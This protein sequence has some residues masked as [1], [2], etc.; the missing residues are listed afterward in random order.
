M[1]IKTCWYIECTCQQPGGNKGLKVPEK[2]A[3]VNADP[4]GM[5][6]TTPQRF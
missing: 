1:F 5:H 2:E 6:S 4:Q 3:Y